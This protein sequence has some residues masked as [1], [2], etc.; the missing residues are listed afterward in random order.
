MYKKIIQI[1]NDID[2]YTCLR[3][4][5]LRQVYLLLRKEINYEKRKDIKQLPK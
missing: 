2:K 4:S 5:I 3:Y 1:N